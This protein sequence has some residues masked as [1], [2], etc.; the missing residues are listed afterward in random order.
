[1]LETYTVKEAGEKNGGNLRRL[2]PRFGLFF[3]IW[4]ASYP[5]KTSQRWQDFPKQVKLYSQSTM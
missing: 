2:M 3:S 1:V 5:S 4:K